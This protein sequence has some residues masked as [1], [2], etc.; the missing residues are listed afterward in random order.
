MWKLQLLPIAVPTGD[1]LANTVVE[2]HT[3]VI[4]SLFMVC[5]REEVLKLKWFRNFVVQCVAQFPASTT[6]WPEKK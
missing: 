1:H 5:L 6:F 4:G 3:Y 2:Q